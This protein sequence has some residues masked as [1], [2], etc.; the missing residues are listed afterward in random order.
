M[1]LTKNSEI[2]R[3]LGRQGGKATLKKH[4]RK[5]FS[6]IGKMKKKKQNEN[7]KNN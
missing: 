4:G 3:I 6:R 7:K 5:F 1:D 2:A